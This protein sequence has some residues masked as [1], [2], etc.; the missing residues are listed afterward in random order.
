MLQLFATTSFASE[1]NSA[2]IAIIIDDIGHNRRRREHAINLPGRLTYAVIPD[3]RHAA[4]LA[5]YANNAGKEVM[6]HLPMENTRNQPLGDI[7]LTREMSRQDFMQV[8][9]TAVAGIP[10][11]SGINNHM[12]SAL[13]QEP[14][15]MSWLMEAV[16]K[17]QLFFVDSRT[18][19]KNVASKVAKQQNIRV[20]S[21][22]VFLDNV[23]TV[24]E[25]DRQF[26]KLI[27]VAK[28]RKTAI[29]IGHPYAETIAY[30]KLALPMLEAEGI[31]VIPVSEVIRLRAT[32]SLIA[33]AIPQTQ[34][35]T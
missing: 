4:S 23:A 13:T 9:E 32:A 19:P 26:R 8:I 24:F 27:D 21:R 31:K 33:S 25:I 3:T 14:Q 18:T 34:P 30:L 16:K 7:A 20:A 35:G 10:F 17:H 22:D 28:R 12:G 5:L 1:S 6:L 29:A 15:A 2:Y 11:V